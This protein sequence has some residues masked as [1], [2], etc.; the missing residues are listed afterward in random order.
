MQS[1][2]PGFHASPFSYCCGDVEFGEYC[3]LAR[4]VLVKDARIGRFTYLN[5]GS[6]A[7]YCEMGNFCS[8]GEEVRIGGLGRHP[9]HVSTHPSFFAPETPTPS[10]HVVPGFQD[11][12]PVTIG[13]DVW[14][15]NRSM[16]MGGVT[17]RTGAVVGAGAVV[18]REVPPYA[19]V[20]GVPARVI[21][22]RLPPELVDRVLAT[23][24]WNWSLSQLRQWGPLIGS[25]DY[26]AFLAKFEANHGRQPD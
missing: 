5:F 11:Y 9:F 2:V 17:V 8:V 6:Q 12:A 22:H 13:H 7:I 23:E 19:I 20:A 26:L 14:I 1:R 4:N 24:W 16:I 3:R 21:G 18:T 10:C 25:D 15:G